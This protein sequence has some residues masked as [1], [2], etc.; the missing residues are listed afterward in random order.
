MSLG[1]QVKNCQAIEI[2]NLR[3]TY[4]DGTQALKDVNLRVENGESVAIIGPNGAGKSTLLLHLNGILKGE[5]EVKIFGLSVSNSNIKEVRRR[6]GLVFQD[7]DDQLFC[8]SVFDDVAFGPINMGLPHDEVI[9][10]T[11]MAL[12]AVGLPGFEKKSAYHLSLGQ[13]K[14]AAIA[15]VLSM[16]PDILAIDEPSSNL[17]P[18]SRRELIKVLRSLPVTKILITH[19]LPFVVE[20]CKRTIIMD[21]G[22]VVADGK[23]EEIFSDGALLEIHGLEIPYGYSAPSLLPTL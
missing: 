16:Q 1:E 13:K 7:P 14:R 3:Y 20:I 18:R 5:G 15:T 11:E 4:P 23:V 19:D 10:R 8:P 2:R 9:L 21:E 12:G 22:K 17:D 6:V